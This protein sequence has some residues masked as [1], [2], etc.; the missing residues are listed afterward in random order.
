MPV[1][2]EEIFPLSA[3]LEQTDAFIEGSKKHVDGWVSFYWGKTIE[4]NRA[5]NDIKGAIV[6]EWLTY[7]RDHSPVRGGGAADR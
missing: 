6:A 2:I 4:E 3:G 5:K 7:F 1:V